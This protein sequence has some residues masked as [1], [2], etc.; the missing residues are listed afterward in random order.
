MTSRA[1]LLTGAAGRQ[2]GSVLRHL[3][4]DG[5]PVRRGHPQLR[6]RTLQDRPREE[7]WARRR[8]ITARRGKTGRPPP[9]PAPHAAS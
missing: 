1:V 9:A 3:P 4:E 6:L 2:G 8:T 7:G 5:W